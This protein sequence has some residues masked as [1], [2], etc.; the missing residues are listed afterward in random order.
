MR[1]DTNFVADGALS[2]NGMALFVNFVPPFV[3][4]WELLRDYVVKFVSWHT[5]VCF[6]C[7]GVIMLCYKMTSRSC[8]VLCVCRLFSIHYSVHDAFAVVIEC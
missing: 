4:H 3:L 2:T 7:Y 8:V 5:K 6:I 1:F